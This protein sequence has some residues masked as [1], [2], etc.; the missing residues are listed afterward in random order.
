MEEKIEFVKEKLLIG[1]SHFQHYVIDKAVSQ[2]SR[3]SNEERLGVAFCA[4]VAIGASLPFLTRRPKFF[5]TGI[6]LMFNIHAIEY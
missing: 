6:F 3:A 2:W 4:G 1:Q 5:L